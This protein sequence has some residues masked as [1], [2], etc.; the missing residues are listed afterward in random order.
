M[1]TL[2]LRAFFSS[3]IPLMASNTQSWNGGARRYSEAQEEKTEDE[4]ATEESSLA[5]AM[6]QILLLYNANT[7]MFTRDSIKSIDAQLD[8]CASTPQDSTRDNKITV[9]ALDG[10]MVEFPL[11]SGLVLD[12]FDSV[13]NDRATEFVLYD[14]LYTWKHKPLINNVIARLLAFTTS[15]SASLSVL[16]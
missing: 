3:K 5:A 15:L 9:Q 6:A 14:A 8:L 4:I 10:A 7:P 11:E 16:N 12:I 2:R 1:V 13:S